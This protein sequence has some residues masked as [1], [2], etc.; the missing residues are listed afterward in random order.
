MDDEVSRFMVG[1][2]MEKKPLG[3]VLRS[4]HHKME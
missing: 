2:G 1:L 3:Q 4:V